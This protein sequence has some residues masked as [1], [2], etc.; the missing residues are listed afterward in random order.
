M[1]WT[2]LTAGLSA[3]E[4]A[5]GRVGAGRAWAMAEHWEQVS[6]GLHW[7]DAVRRGRT[8]GFGW[9]LTFDFPSRDSVNVR[10]SIVPED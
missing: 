4:P 9:C 10:R 1:R 7:G 6:A 8:T 5:G 2:R 3:V